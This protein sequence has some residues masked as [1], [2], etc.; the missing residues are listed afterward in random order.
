MTAITQKQ[1]VILNFIK[2]F[3]E[4]KGYSPTFQEIA[5][6]IG[7]KSLA[8]VHKHIGNLVKKGKLKRDY[9]TSRSLEIVEDVPMGPRFSFWT[10]ERLWDN[11]DNCFW[12]K[13]KR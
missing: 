3:V 8:T 9:N 2:S 11:V 10:P 13:E 5:D 1:S 12:V 4:E 6:G 7:L